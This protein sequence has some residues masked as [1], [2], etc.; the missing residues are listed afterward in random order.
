MVIA[1]TIAASLAL[2]GLRISLSSLALYTQSPESNLSLT[3]STALFSSLVSLVSN[4]SSS[5]ACIRETISFHHSVCFQVRMVASGTLVISAACLEFPH[6]AKQHTTSIFLAS[7]Y[8]LR[9]LGSCILR[10]SSVVGFPLFF[11][12]LSLETRIV[13][14]KEDISKVI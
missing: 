10:Y 8:L 2:I 9:Y 6:T 11:R 5:S 3:C 1:V 12:R 13:S 14:G 4:S 7:E